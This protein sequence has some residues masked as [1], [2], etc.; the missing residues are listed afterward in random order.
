MRSKTAVAQIG[1]LA[2]M[3]TLYPNPNN[4]NFTLHASLD[5]TQAGPVAVEVTD[6]IGQ[7]VYSGDAQVQSGILNKEISIP[8]LCQGMYM[9]HLKTTDAAATIRF[10]I[11]K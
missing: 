5:E 11:R 6:M 7:Q 2:G 1:S 8:G 9:L 10:I 3:L 4:G